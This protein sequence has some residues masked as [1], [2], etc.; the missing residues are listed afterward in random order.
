MMKLLSSSKNSKEKVL[1]DYIVQNKDSFYRIAYSYTKN[2]DDALD[3]VHEAICKSLSKINKLKDINNIKSIYLENNELVDRQV[4]ND[5]YEDIDLHRALN[6]LSDEYK[7]IIILR[8]FEDMKIE[9]IANI[10]DE[11]VNTIKTR[12]YS[13]LRKLKVNIYE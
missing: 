8:Y 3:V 9:D 12:L 7:T 13:A 10:L 11:N 5:T 2:E 6:I 4:Y 1:K